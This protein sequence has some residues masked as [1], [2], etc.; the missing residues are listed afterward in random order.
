MKS[1]PL[2]QDEE[3][4]LKALYALEILDTEA[5]ACFD[6]LVWMASAVCETPIALVSLIDRERQWFKARVGLDATETH[7]DFAF[8][9]HAILGEGTFVV[10]SAKLDERFADNPLV[11]GAPFV[12]FYAG[13][14]LR[15]EAGHAL[16]TLCVIDHTPRELTAKQISQ[17]EVLARQAQ[18]T[19]VLRD[20]NRV[21]REQVEALRVLSK[22]REMFA[23]IAE[24]MNVGVL[25][26]ELM[27][28]PA[29]LDMVIRFAN[30]AAFTR[31]GRA[32]GSAS[33]L[34]G[35][36]F[37]E[38]APVG[39]GHVV[40]DA[41]LQVVETHESVTLQDVSWGHGQAARI[42]TVWAFSMGNHWVGL[43]LADVTERRQFELHKLNFAATVSHE[44]RTP[45]T[46]LRGALGLLL[47]G[48][49]GELSDDGRELMELAQSNTVRLGLL[50]DDLLDLERLR[51][52]QLEI[53]CARFDAE[54]WLHEVVAQLKTVFNAR[55]ISS[56]VRCPLPVEIMAD[57]ARMTQVLVNL[58]SNAVKFSPEKSQVTVECVQ[59]DTGAV[60]VSVSDQGSGI[61]EA[62]RARMFEPFVR[63]DASDGSRTKGTG[64]GLSISHT[65]VHQHGG[66]MGV[67]DVEPTG[68]RFWF[69]IPSDH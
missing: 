11:D 21:V 55:G 16:G 38:I 42:Y 1:A 14:P 13:A 27:H 24:H 9:A 68:S 57:R 59:D 20:R 47:G 32:A 64:L 52:G 26:L 39:P 7:R 40:Y 62:D 41:I 3:A 8:C 65:L 22:Q 28:Q 15:D 49:V 53:K 35:Q 61:A 60:C 12:E 58:L 30:Q 36:S 31:D 10:P 46:A 34:T 69:T 33:S 63:L 5:E 67:S 56:V 4:R 50:V 48:V 29:D 43:A 2:A 44:L 23:S 18:R 6:D 19:L 37:F 54:A 17:L 66:E 45:L 51:S 25:V